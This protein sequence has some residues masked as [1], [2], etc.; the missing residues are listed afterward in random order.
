MSK[1]PDL[2]EKCVDALCEQ[3]CDKVNAYISA[4]E[5]GEDLPEVAELTETERSYVLE[6]LVAIMAVYDGSC[7]G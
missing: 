3:G 7:D 6:Q 5:H 4:L 2:I 1:Q